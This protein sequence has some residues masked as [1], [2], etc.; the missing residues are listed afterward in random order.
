MLSSAFRIALAFF[1]SVT[2]KTNTLPSEQCPKTC[3]ILSQDSC[4]VRF[5][6]IVFLDDF[7]C[8]QEAFMLFGTQSEAETE[9]VLQVQAHF[10]FFF[11]FFSWKMEGVSLSSTRRQK[12]PKMEVKLIPPNFRHLHTDLYIYATQA[13]LDS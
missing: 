13:P 8:H 6:I 1:I 9:T 10:F 4:N 11:T 5:R 7:L 3:Y 2:D 12:V